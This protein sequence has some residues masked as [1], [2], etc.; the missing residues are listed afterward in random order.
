MLTSVSFS[1]INTQVWMS[2]IANLRKKQQDFEYVILKQFTI[3]S[4]V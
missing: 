1:Q 2:L 3:G 4:I